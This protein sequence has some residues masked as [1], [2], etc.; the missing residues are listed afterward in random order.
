MKWF[1]CLN[2]E[3]PENGAPLAAPPT[4]PKGPGQMLNR[5]LV[6][7]VMWFRLSNR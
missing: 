5:P 2:G 1:E 3:Q 4:T 6:L 7:T